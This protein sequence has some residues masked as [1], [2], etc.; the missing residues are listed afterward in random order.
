MVVI[1]LYMSFPYKC[2]TCNLTLTGDG[3]MRDGKTFCNNGCFSRYG[4]PSL[5]PKYVPK[6]RGCN[7]C[8]VEYDTNMHAGV[9]F[10]TLWFC[11]P[12]HLELANPRPKLMAVGGYPAVVPHVIGHPLV[13]PHMGLPV[14]T[15]HM[16]TAH[17][18]ITAPNAGQHVF[19]RH[20]AHRRIGYPYPGFFP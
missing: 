15:H 2:C 12:E 11:C 4:R 1:N 9:P 19:A 7:Y 20:I 5:L 14:M 16:G 8:F 18:V 17:L 13:P 6:P 10:K 3:I